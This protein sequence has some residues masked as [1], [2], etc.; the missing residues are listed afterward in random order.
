MNPDKE[1]NISI[2]NDLISSLRKTIDETE[3]VHFYKIKFV[4]FGFIPLNNP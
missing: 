2:F 1:Y 3:K 4:L